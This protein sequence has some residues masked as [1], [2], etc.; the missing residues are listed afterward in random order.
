MHVFQW[1]FPVVAWPP[2]RPCKMWSTIL[3]KVKF[4]LFA[5]AYSGNIG[6]IINK[7]YWFWLQYIVKVIQ[8][9]GCGCNFIKRPIT[10]YNDV[11]MSTMASQITSLTVVYS[12]V[13]SRTYQR[14]HQSSASLA[15]VRGIYRW[16]VNS[17]HKFPVTWKT[18]PFDDVIMSINRPITIVSNWE[19]T[20]H[21]TK[22]YTDNIFNIQHRYT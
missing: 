20:V 5:W 15:S 11:I 7:K 14:K 19:K 21:W 9:C 4:C 1:S 6:F 16:P 3:D 22:H 12:T 10:H 17:P 18:V 13:Y 8:I 2:K